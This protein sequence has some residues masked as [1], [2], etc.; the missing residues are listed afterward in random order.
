[1]QE[2]SIYILRLKAK[3]DLLKME[4]QYNLL[5]IEQ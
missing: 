4:V 5:F 2:H 1:M 3:Q